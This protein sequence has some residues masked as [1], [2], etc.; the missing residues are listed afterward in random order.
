MGRRKRVVINQAKN[1]IKAW[2]AAIKVGGK[3]M[4]L[5]SRHDHKNKTNDK[6]CLD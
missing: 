1:I 3:G 5:S 2:T 6:M 4:H